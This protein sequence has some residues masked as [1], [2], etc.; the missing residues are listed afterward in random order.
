LSGYG[1]E[2][3]LALFQELQRK[4]S[5]LPG[6]RS[7]ATAQLVPLGGWNWGNEIKAPASSV[8]SREYVECGENSTT[9]GYFGTLGIELVAGRDFTGDDNAHAAKVAIL[10][11]HFARFLFGNVDPVGQIIHLG[12]SGEDARIVGVVRDSRY[13]SVQEKPTRFLYVPFEQGDEEIPPQAAFFV[14]TLASEQTAMRSIR[15]AVRQ[16]DSNLP[17]GHLRTMRTILDES[18]Y[19]ERLMAILAAAFGVLAAVLAAVG[20]Y[21]SVS[22]SVARRTREFGI[23]MVLGAVPERL[24]LCV[25][26]DVGR[27]LAIGIGLGLPTVFLLGRL[28]ESQLYGVRG[29]DPL[30]LAGGTALIVAVGLLAAL[31]PAIRAMRIE[32]VTAIRYE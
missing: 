22:Y 16:L 31:A 23:R 3:R 13:S 25:L 30:A 17:I 28:A 14:R 32:P 5:Q 26:G 18:I 9:P 15:A 21:G 29:H 11:Q 12:A 20:V 8:A 4:L 6:V 19:T 2:R 7:A 1:P 27:L 10:N 24:L